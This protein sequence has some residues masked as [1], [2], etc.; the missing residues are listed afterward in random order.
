[1]SPATN[2]A[3]I[4][5]KVSLDTTGI[6]KGVKAAKKG[7]AQVG[8]SALKHS[9]AIG[10][11]M[12]AAGAAITGIV[13]KTAKDASAFTEAMGAVATLGVKDMKG[14]ESAV[15][16]VAQTYGLDLIKSVKGAYQV[17]SAG[18]SEMEAPLIMEKA[19][20]AAIAGQTDLS[21][22]IELGTGIT[23]AFGG[24]LRDIDGIFTEVFTAVK[25]GVTTFEELAADRGIT[26]AQFAF[27]LPV[28]THSPV[29]EISEGEYM[30]LQV[31]GHEQRELS[32]RTL[33]RREENL[34]TSWLEGLLESAEVEK[35]E[36]W[37]SRIPRTPTLDPRLL[38]PTPTPEG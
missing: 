9:K 36:Y 21:T 24:S 22:A 29:V 15:K 13:A 11:A 25:N 27:P 12:T 1:M 38:I 19:A 18:V 35:H 31:T 7:F 6:D 14:M 20:R 5:G 10:I 33:S 2:I 23:D 28:G 17:I 8:K 34:Y 37:R 26:V 16:E 30:L 4:S 3:G 32:S